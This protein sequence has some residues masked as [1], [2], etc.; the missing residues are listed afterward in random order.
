MGEHYQWEFLFLSSFCLPLFIVWGGCVSSIQCG[1]CVRTQL[2]PD[3][4]QSPAPSFS[5]WRT[6]PCCCPLG[7]PSGLHTGKTMNYILNLFLFKFEFIFFLQVNS[8]IV[9][10]TIK[11]K[12]K[13]QMI[14]LMHTQQISDPTLDLTNKVMLLQKNCWIIFCLAHECEDSQKAFKCFLLVL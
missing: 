4:T 11:L 7:Q 13:G 6:R 2:K 14:P 10:Y 12:P 3:S 8:V 5:V 9:Q 1:T